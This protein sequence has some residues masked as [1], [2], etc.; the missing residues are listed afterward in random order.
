MFTLP[1]FIALCSA[2]ALTACSADAVTSAPDDD[3]RVEHREVAS[4][5]RDNSLGPCSEPANAGAPSCQPVCGDGR[6]DIGE[7]CDDGN[8]RNGDACENNCTFS[9]CGN[10]IKDAGEQ[11][12]DGNAINGDACEGNCTLPTCGNGI[13]DCSEQ[14]DDGNAA[15][16]DAC[17]SDCTAPACGNGIIDAGEQC[18]DG[19][20]S[21]GAG[22]RCNAACRLNVCGDGDLR[23]GIEQ[24]DD[25]STTDGDA[26]EAN[27]TLARCGNGI[28][29]SGE[30]CDDGNTTNG[31]G[32]NSSCA[33][34]VFAYLKASNTGAADVFGASVALSADGS[35]LAVG[36]IGEASAATGIGGNQ[37]DNSMILAG[38]V[39]V[40]TR[41]GTTWVQQA[42]LKA[43][44]TG[45]RDEFGWS[46]AL[47]AD[48]STLAV[49]ARGEDSAATGIGGNQADDSAGNAGAVYV[50]TRSG[51][52][53][54]QQ[55]YVKASNT[56]AGDQFGTSVTLSAGGATMAVGAI[57]E[58][59]AATGIGGNQADN[60]APDAG[61]VYVF[62]RSGS[63]WSQ[64]AYVKASNT[65]AGE[66]FGT[67]V[68]LSADGS[69]LA[70]GAQAENS[71]ATGIDGN[72]GNHLAAGSGAVY[73]FTRS[74]TTWSQQA[75]IKASNTGS[76]IGSGDAFGASVVLSADGSTL[77]VGAV[78]EDSAATGIGGDQA[79]NAA[80]NAGAV[81]VFTR[82]GTTWSQQAYVKASN[83]G[84]G[85]S[86]GSSVALS[87]DGS[88]LAVSA[89][90][91]DS[92]ATGI[93][94]D[95]ADN[96][97]SS[98]GAV[99][100]FTR[101]ST[102][103]NQQAYVKAPNP[104]ANDQFGYSVAL[105]ADGTLAVVAVNEDSAATGIG[106]NQAN[107]SATDSGAVYVL[108]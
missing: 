38:A 90:G 95:Q 65:G 17:E 7:Q 102:T 33:V 21:N 37:A 20:D 70:V 14:C 88:T 74:G 9:R 71:A 1:Q 13:V 79:D 58:S 68:G 66:L 91:E 96:A 98:T 11:C 108:Q 97:A 53:W 94:G 39:Y 56:G 81:Y 16:G 93:G 64:Q 107:N 46:V 62:T 49:G 35:T 83:T 80:S 41:S 101:S 23:L 4:D 22:R 54:S 43:S 50:F 28:I 85:D 30:Q 76:G 19:P 40:F 104:G 51:T 36:A 31:D 42:Y 82:S 105:A 27:C 32:C 24:C 47:S 45:A 6:V 3:P 2:V 75:Y 60:A 73:A 26:C 87:A 86:L 57:R 48:G 78:G 12:D 92:A 103:W 44:N 18:D 52:T 67:S 89:V 69:T 100:V 34:S 8:T 63:A 77:A 99:Y 106:G 61:A 5:Q 72:Q 29:D 59:S 25:G 55:A 84:T 15:D 10:G